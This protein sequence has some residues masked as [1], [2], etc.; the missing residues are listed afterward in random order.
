MQIPA[1]LH[2]DVT[3]T[4]ETP[5]AAVREAEMPH[6]PLVLWE[7]QRGSRVHMRPECLTLS[8]KLPATQEET[9]SDLQMGQA[10]QISVCSCQLRSGRSDH[11]EEQVRTT[12]HSHTHS[13]GS[14]VSTAAPF[15]TA[16]ET[17]LFSFKKICNFRRLSYSQV[18]SQ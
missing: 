15:L 9:T 14:R 7:A 18:T 11:L 4:R 13:Y 5:D 6:S 12:L 3:K 1:A 10:A 16:R 17:G 2:L 8:I